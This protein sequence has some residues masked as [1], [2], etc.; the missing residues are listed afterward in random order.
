M[1]LD[2][3]FQQRLNEARTLFAEGKAP[4]AEKIYR[5]LLVPDLPA[6]GRI[7]VQDGLARCL[8][9]QG[10][11]DEADEAFRESLR[12]LEELFGPDHIHVAGGLQNLARLRSERGEWE[13]AALLGERALDILRRGLPPDDLRIADAL[14]NLSSHQYAAKKYEIAEANLKAA[15]KLW[16]AREGRRCFGVSTCLNNL[17]RICEERGETRQGVLYHQEAVSIRKE[18]LGDHPE[19]AFS[20]GNYGA[21]LAGD[22][23]WDKAAQALEE[24]LACYERLGLA[25]SPDAATCRSNLSMCRRA[26][27]QAREG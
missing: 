7:L 14:L 23:Q 22:A 2:A 20:L 3:V 19:T 27:R 5:E 21:A 15:M 6:G 9:V 1:Q 24:A 25:D 11:M 17:G 10:R 16:E 13:E 18:I 8:H 26:A 12:H 4:A